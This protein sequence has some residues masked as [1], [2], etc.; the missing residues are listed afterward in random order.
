MTALMA[1]DLCALL[2]SFVMAY[3]ARLVTGGSLVPENYLGLLPSLVLFLVLYTAFGLYPGVPCPPHEELKRLTI[4]TSMVFLFLSVIVFLA[5]QGIVY[6]RSIMLASWAFAVVLVPVFR[7]GARRVFA[8]RSWWG[9]PVLL[10]ALPGKGKPA[11][12][13]FREH[14]ERGLYIAR[15][16]PLVQENTADAS[17][18]ESIALHD[19]PRAEAAFAALRAAHPRAIALILADSLSQEEQQ[20]LVMMAS[21]YFRQIIVQPETSWWTKHITLHVADI[22]SGLA[23]TLRQNL[24]DPNRM[25][26]KRFLDLLLCFLGSVVLIPLIPILAL[27]IRL[28]S[29]GPVFFSQWRI[30]QEGRP[31]RVYKFRTMVIDAEQVLDNVLAHDPALQEEWLRDQKLAHDPRMTRM[32]RFLRHTSLDELPQIFNVLKNEMSLVGPRPIVDSEIERY[33][34]SFELYRRVKPGITGLWQVSGRNDVDYADRVELDRYYI[35]NW[36][37]WLDI[38]ILFRTFPAILTGRGAC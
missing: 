33:G 1:S 10:F 30:G 25:R 24:L 20:E 9:Y 28:D 21:R 38:Y 27:C 7:F 5:Q 31:I 19:R 18:K 6:S 14:L 4:A 32:G 34:E 8:G 2:L 11:L 3:L 12:D 29:K 36:S 16:V 23:L 37:V 17:S 35:Y 15:A 13:S 22:P 26:M